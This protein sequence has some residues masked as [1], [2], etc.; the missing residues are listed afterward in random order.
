MAQGTRAARGTSTECRVG[1]RVGRAVTAAG[2]DDDCV[3]VCVNYH[4]YA[5][6][7]ANANYAAAGTVVWQ[8]RT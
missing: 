1:G 4:F 3:C 7:A 6:G 8:D 5:A 2:S